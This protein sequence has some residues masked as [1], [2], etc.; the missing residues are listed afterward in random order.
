MRTRI[1]TGWI[2]DIRDD[3]DFVGTGPFGLAALPTL[4]VDLRKTPYMPP[5]TNQLQ[6]NSC[7]ANATSSVF[8]YMLRKLGLPD[9]QPSRL[10]TYYFARAR[11]G[12]ENEDDGCM[13][14][15]AMQS[16]IS[17]GTIAELYWPFSEDNAIINTRPSQ[18]N[19]HDALSHR[20]VEGKYVRMLANDDLYHLKHS[21]SLGLPF[22][23]GIPCYT[24]FFDVGSS[25]IV[26][27]PTNGE[28]LEGFH[29]MYIV[30]YSEAQQIFITVNSWGEDDGDH[31]VRY[32]PYQYVKRYGEDLWRVEGLISN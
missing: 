27:M 32:L 5:V 8:R 6:T 16:L 28:T 31:G 11:Q 24:S 15:D 25:G 20:I 29:M 23:I 2:R 4:D 19:L 14:R 18:Q 10:F 13:P 3:R 1:G 12:W 17:N 22:T 30:G 21:L 26:H 9:F 7:V